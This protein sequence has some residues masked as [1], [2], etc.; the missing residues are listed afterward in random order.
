MWTQVAPFLSKYKD[1]TIWDPFFCTGR[2]KTCLTR[3][4]FH[5]VLHVDGV[6]FLSLDV[7][8]AGVEVIV[9]NPPYSILQP[10]LRRISTWGMPAV[11]LIPS[12]TV[13]TRYFSEIMSGA[14]DAGEIELLVPRKRIEYLLPNGRKLHN[15]GFPSLWLCFRIGIGSPLTWM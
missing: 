7:P 15:V 14:I 5:S 6:D 12:S 3:L 4:G 10:I 9:T 1:M 13:Q 2:A 8:P 11:L